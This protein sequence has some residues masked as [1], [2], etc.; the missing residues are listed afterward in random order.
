MAYEV[1]CKQC[2]CK[3]LTYE[4]WQKKYK[5]PIAICKKC[6]NEYLDPRCHELAIEGIPQEEFKVSKDFILLL[7]GGLIAWRG[8]VLFGMHMLGTLASTQW[9]LPTVI[10]ILGIALILV[11]ILDLIS[12]LT[13][14]KKRKYEK[15]LEES[16]NRI[17]DDN[18]VL[19]L[20]Q[21]G[22]MR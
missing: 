3:L 15:L 8:Y 14:L 21:I 4:K 16:Q 13:G 9:L 7:V 1:Y 6:G 2:N 5:S 19:K 12:I 11:S 17:K 10:L 20:K 22:Y 18:Y